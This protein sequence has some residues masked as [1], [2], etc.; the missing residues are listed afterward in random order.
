M[1]PV[2]KEPED[3]PMSDEI[4]NICVLRAIV[5]HARDEASNLRQ[6]YSDKEQHDI[7]DNIKRAYRHL[8]A[9]ADILDE[10]YAKQKENEECTP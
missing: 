6:A 9:A 3:R 8:T 7:A 10:A 5:E 2:D 4:Y 1:I